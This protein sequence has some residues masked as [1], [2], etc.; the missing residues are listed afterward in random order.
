LG[1]VDVLLNEPPKRSA[2]ELSGVERRG[3]SKIEKSKIVNWKIV[4]VAS[5][6]DHGPASTITGVAKELAPPPHVGG[7]ERRRSPRLGVPSRNSFSPR[8]HRLLLLD[9]EWNGENSNNSMN[10]SRVEAGWCCPLGDHRQ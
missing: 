5:K 9:H 7:Y 1:S 8:R 6:Q 3:K 2:A 10:F 4:L